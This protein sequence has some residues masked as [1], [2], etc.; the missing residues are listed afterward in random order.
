MFKLFNCKECDCYGINQSIL[1]FYF[2]FYLGVILI[3][4]SL[5]FK[6]NCIFVLKEIKLTFRPCLTY[7]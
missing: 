6:N 7:F 5:I 3:K 2:S 4:L 1:T